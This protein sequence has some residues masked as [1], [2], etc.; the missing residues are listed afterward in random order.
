MIASKIEELL[1]ENFDNFSLNSKKST[2]NK[3]CFVL[4]SVDRHST[5]AQLQSILANNDIAYSSLHMT[6]YSH[7][8]DVDLVDSDNHKYIFVYKPSRDG[9]AST[10]TDMTLITESAQCVYCAVSGQLGRTISHDDVAT[11]AKTFSTHFSIPIPV[12]KVIDELP[13]QWKVSSSLIA[14]QIRYDFPD[15]SYVFHKDSNLVSNLNS[16]FQK[17]NSSRIR[18]LNKWSPADIWMQ[19]MNDDIEAI[20]ESPQNLHEYNEKLK[21]LAQKNRLVGISLKQATK[22]VRSKKYNFFR[23][24]VDP[25]FLDEII[26]AKNGDIFSSKDIYLKALDSEHNSKL[27]QFRTFETGRSWQG[28]I[29]SRNSNMGKIGYGSINQLLIDNGYSELDNQLSVCQRIAN[30][31]SRTIK[32][33]YE[34]YE[35]TSCQNVLS[36][37][38]FRKMIEQKSN[39]WKIS[40]FL[41]T[42]LTS[43]LCKNIEKSNDFVT[44]L[45]G[46]ASSA[47]KH[48]AP[49]IKYY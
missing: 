23:P 43:N 21:F 25:H 5:K 22:N 10:G 33:F 14:D 34:N 47:T 46:Y 12:E 44:D 17:L 7:T 18:N 32:V 16:T 3:T 28:E 13:D 49:F 45:F 26:L 15:G 20:L 2:V 37:K 39:D 40:M 30:G 11:H 42:Q 8:V 35:L 29:K 48:S 19:K 6:S 36:Y 31:D 41:G 1:S 9:G 24:S 38:E 27:I 4:K